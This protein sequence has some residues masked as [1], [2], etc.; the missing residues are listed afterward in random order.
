MLPGFD[1]SK[2]QDPTANYNVSAGL[3]PL[4]KF[5]GQIIGKTIYPNT[6]GKPPVVN[7]Y[8]AI[9]TQLPNEESI[10]KARDVF[11]FGP[12]PTPGVSGGKPL[13]SLVPYRPGGI[14]PG[15]PPPG[16][17]RRPGPPVPRRDPKLPPNDFPKK[18]KTTPRR[19]PVRPPWS[20]GVY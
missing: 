5:L 14:L 16:K 3:S 1:W 4:A 20:R 18:P 6:Y 7:P 8:D 15:E 12:T 19:P 2:I 13:Q 9:P 10:N 11:G 17:P